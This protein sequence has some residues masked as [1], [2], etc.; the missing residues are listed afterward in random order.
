MTKLDIEFFIQNSTPIP[1][2]GCWIW[3]RGTNGRG[4]GWL[5]HPSL[6]STAHRISYQVANNIILP[7]HID[8]CHSCDI[9]LCVNPDHLFAGTRKD[10]MQDCVRKGRLRPPKLRGDKCPA[11]KL[12]SNQVLEI[13]ASSEKYKILA[14]RYGVTVRTI[15]GI[16]TRETWWY[17]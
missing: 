14:I 10:N 1:F 17:I 16:K 5:R 8:V 3:D 4:Y 6:T 15:A 9:R 13:R 7:R 2:S 11:S 12:T